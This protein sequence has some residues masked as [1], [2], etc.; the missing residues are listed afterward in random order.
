MCVSSSTISQNVTFT[1]GYSAITL[2]HGINADVHNNVFNNN[3]ALV[4]DSMLVVDQSQ[5]TLKK[6]QS[7]YRKSTDSPEKSSY[8]VQSNMVKT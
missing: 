3:S 8:N 5:V 2:L 4:G 7:N 1:L 6:E